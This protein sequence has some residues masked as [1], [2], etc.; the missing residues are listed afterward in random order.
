MITLDQIIGSNLEMLKAQEASLKQSL[1]FVQKAIQLFESKNGSSKIRKRRGRK[2]AS[3]PASVVAKATK[4]KAKTRTREGGKHI[5]RI[6]AVLK[7]KKTPI[8]SG[9]LI[10]T[11]FKKQSVDKDRSHFARL[12]YP[13]L[14]NA[15]K[16]KILKLKN[17]KIHIT[18]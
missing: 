6:L 4:V 16:S 1:D 2:R 11:L 7:E 12:I 13:T 14:T 5:D 18:S 10:D 9:E 17:R 3:K 15:Y 8:S